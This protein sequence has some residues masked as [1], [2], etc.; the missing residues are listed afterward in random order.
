[1]K[2]S[3]FNILTLQN[4]NF[5]LREAPDP[6]VPSARAFIWLQAHARLKPQKD[7]VLQKCKQNVGAKEAQALS[8]VA[9]HGCKS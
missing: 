1:M 8:F 9:L 3:H 5:P 4:L 7:K 6:F 2:A